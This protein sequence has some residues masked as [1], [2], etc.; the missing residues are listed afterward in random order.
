MLTNYDASGIWPLAIL[1]LP[2]KIP[3]PYCMFSATNGSTYYFQLNG[4]FSFSETPTN[5]FRFHLVASTSP[6]ISDQPASLT[7]SCNGSALLKLATASLTPASIQWQFNGADIPGANVA[8]LPLTNVVPAQAGDYRAIVRNASGSVTSAPAHLW[9]TVVDQPPILSVL[10]GF[11]AE[12]FAFALGGEPGRAYRIESSTNLLNWAQE[13]SF[14]SGSIYPVFLTSVILN[15]GF[16]SSLDLPKTGGQ[17]CFRASAYA[18]SNEICNLN[19]KIIRFAKDLWARERN[20]STRDTPQPVDLFGSNAV[21]NISRPQCP[22]G[23]WYYYYAVGSYP[24]CTI[25][26]HVL[27]EPP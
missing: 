25:P 24:T 6:V 3:R 7:V 16:V 23:G 13:N 11:Y 20:Y 2:W 10:P 21:L 18:P 5:I 27:E 22:Q 14:D 1:H 12:R 26:G 19:L 9:I 8:V 17:K 15:N 4:P